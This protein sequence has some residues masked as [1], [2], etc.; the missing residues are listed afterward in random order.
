M[1]LTIDIGNSNICFGVYEGKNALFTA[2]AKTDPL[3]TE[4]E[5]AVL[6]SQIFRLHQSDP[7]QLTGAAISSVVPALTA[8]FHDAVRILGNGHIPTI[9]V[10]PGVKTGLN[11]RIDEPASLGADLAC[12]AV[13]AAEK[14]PLPAIIIDLG[15]ATK[16]TVV[17]ED[18][19]F[20]GGAILPGVKISLEALSGSASLLPSIGLGTGKIKTIGSNTVDCMLSGVVLGTAC[21]VDGL[22]ERYREELGEVPTVVACGGLSPAIVPHCRTNIILDQDLL[23]DGLA[24]AGALV[25]QQ[26]IIGKAGVVRGALSAGHHQHA[27][28]AA[29]IAGHVFAVR[30]A[31]LP[32]HMAHEC[33]RKK[34]EKGA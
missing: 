4:T 5:Y 1:I 25:S 6:L 24:V 13:G 11:I 18:R 26:N 29:G 27:A 10:G 19:S 9:V 8:V 28:G 34:E 20:I 22:I 15:T 33:L 7:A 30:Y 21:M 3:R 16:I 32:H 2:R 12:T 17:T 23:L 14:Y 31:D